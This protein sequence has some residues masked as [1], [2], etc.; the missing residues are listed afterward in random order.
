MLFWRLLYFLFLGRMF[1]LSLLFHHLDPGQ[2][3]M[4]PQPVFGRCTHRINLLS[5]IDV[6]SFFYP[7]TL[8]LASLFMAYN[9]IHRPLSVFLREWISTHVSRWR[10]VVWRLLSVKY[11]TVLSSSRTLLS[12]CKLRYWKMELNENVWTCLCVFVRLYCMWGKGL[13]GVFLYKG[14]TSMHTVTSVE[15][16][17]SL[18]SSQITQLFSI[19]IMLRRPFHPSPLTVFHCQFQLRNKITFLPHR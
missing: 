15:V 3:L 10:W 4:S 18:D 12:R 2:K 9:Q 8:K 17:W 13:L 5:I 16:Y 6:A 7:S 1:R 14:N 11:P 19:L